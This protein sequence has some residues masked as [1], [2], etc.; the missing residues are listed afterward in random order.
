M[1]QLRCSV[2]RS[3]GRRRLNNGMTG[4]MIVARS[5]LPDRRVPS[6]RTL[7]E[8][9]RVPAEHRVNFDRQEKVRLASSPPRWPLSPAETGPPCDVAV[10]AG[11][12]KREP[13]GMPASLSTRSVMVSVRVSRSSPTRRRCTAAGE[14]PVPA[15]LRLE[16]FDPELRPSMRSRRRSRAEPEERSAFHRLGDTAQ[17]QRVVRQGRSEIRAPSG[18]P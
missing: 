8:R 15:M 16:A 11:T 18:S 3:S 5:K 2:R 14:P 6:S 4:S 1:T 9:G 7:I 13:A 12:M 10:T 17:L